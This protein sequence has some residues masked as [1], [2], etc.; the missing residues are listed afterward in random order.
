MLR[1]LGGRQNLGWPAT[2]LVVALGLAFLLH[3]SEGKD[4][5]QCRSPGLLQKAVQ[6]VEGAWLRSAENSELSRVAQSNLRVPIAS[7]TR[8]WPCLK[9]AWLTSLPLPADPCR[10]SLEAAL[11]AQ[12]L[13]PA[14]GR[15]T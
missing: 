8:G 7:P 12:L 13:Q 11:V 9:P 14:A 15:L 2:W 6:A 10:C 4:L 5:Q 3:M 1:M